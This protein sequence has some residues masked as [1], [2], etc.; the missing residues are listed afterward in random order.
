MVLPFKSHI[1]KLPAYKPPVVPPGAMRVVDLSSNENPLGPSPKA[2]AAVQKALGTI[3]RY[4]D[5][6]GSA[7][8]AALAKRWGLTPSNVALSNGADEWVLLLCLSLVDPGNCPLVLLSFA[9]HRPF[10][11]L[12][13]TACFA[14][15]PEATCPGSA[16]QSPA[17]G[18][19]WSP[20]RLSTGAGRDR[21][22]PPDTR[23]YSRSHHGSGPL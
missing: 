17:A 2:V 9:W 23:G 11:A 1:A 3:N 8:K 15:V 21:S 10:T 4:P 7:L 22:S 16:G 20:R 5:A 14:A 12:P 19:R 13:G 18:S 6:S